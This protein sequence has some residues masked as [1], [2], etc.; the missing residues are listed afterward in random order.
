MTLG[1]SGTGESLPKQKNLAVH[2]T[3]AVE[4]NL[5]KRHP[6][7]FENEIRKISHEGKAGDV[8][9]IFDNNNAFL[10]AGLYDPHGPIRVRVLQHNQPRRIDEVLIDELVSCS[11]KR[12]DGIIPADTDGYRLING[13]NDGLPG[14]VADRYADT[15]VIK[16]YSSCWA[17]W[18]SAV[19][20]GLTRHAPWH[21]R[22]VLLLSRQLQR[23]D[24]ALLR[25]MAH[26]TVLHGAPLDDAIVFRECGLL[27]EADPLRGQKTGFFLDQRDNRRRVE[28]LARGARVLN[29]FSYTGGF[30]LYAARGGAARVTSVDVSQPALDAAERNFAL[31]RPLHAAVRRAAH[32]GLAGD[33]FAVMRQLQ[34]EGQTYSLVIV[35]PPSMANKAEQRQL[36]IARCS[37]R[38]APP[39]L[40][41]RTA[42]VS[43][44]D[45][46]RLLPAHTRV[47]RLQCVVTR[48]LAAAPAARSLAAALA[49]KTTLG[50]PLLPLGGAATIG[51]Q[52]VS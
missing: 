10:A 4:T 51:W 14:I 49:Q 50:Q 30:S 41:I 19:E 38:A 21:S 11:I 2:V 15:V 42:G 48:S 29:V 45:T 24:P 13:D 44:A 12:R 52:L 23:L 7:V 27:F 34:A 6:W 36:A 9:I 37:P 22:R 3:R 26:G 17:P 47:R 32:T 43:T 35:D 18:L 46:R 5:R 16:I 40:R 33:A 1:G 39:S 25:G 28:A 20:A 8:A 31:N